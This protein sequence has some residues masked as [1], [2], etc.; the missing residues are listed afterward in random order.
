ASAD[1]RRLLSAFKYQSNNVT[2]HSDRAV[3]PAAR[4][5]WSSWNYLIDKDGR[6]STHYWMN[7]LQGVSKKQD[8]FV[9][10]NAEHLIDEKLSHRSFVYEHPLFTIDALNAQ[11]EL[12]ILNQRASQVYF[13]GSYF[14]YGFHED[15]LCSALE[16]ANTLCGSLVSL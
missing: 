11:A 4:P 13:C 15:A 16:L 7:S 14:R 8:Y 1:E 6:A 9:S 12:P 5:C 2:L 3:M 10:L